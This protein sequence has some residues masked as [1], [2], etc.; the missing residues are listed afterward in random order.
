MIRILA[1][2]AVV[3]ASG[4]TIS[5]ASQPMLRFEHATYGEAYAKPATAFPTFGQT[6]VPAGQDT[7]A[8]GPT[9]TGGA[10]AA[11]LRRDLDDC[12]TGTRPPTIASGPIPNQAEQQEHDQ[13]LRACLTRRGW[14]WTLEAPK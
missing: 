13:A 5:C 7:I 2:I 9:V 4:L 6:V 8:W 14:R 12:V 1:T 11:A 10:G 3:A